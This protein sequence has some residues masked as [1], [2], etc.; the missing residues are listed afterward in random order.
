MRPIDLTNQRFGKLTALRLSEQKGNGRLWVCKCDCGTEVEVEAFGLNNGKRVSCGCTRNLN[1]VG[2]RFG[3][4]T[5]LTKQ[6][7]HQ[8]GRSDW[9]CQCECGGTCV[10]NISKLMCGIR[11]SCGCERKPCPKRLSDAE[12]AINK[13]WHSYLGN[14]R[15]KAISFELDRD[16]F[17]RLLTGNCYYCGLL[18]SKRVRLTHRTCNFLWNGIDRLNNDRGYEPD[19]VVSCCSVCNFRKGTT[20]SDEFLAW[21]ASVARHRGLSRV[22]AN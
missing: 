6:T 16:T 13:I 14:A 12:A 1:L 11:K 4:S 15:H 21:I 5:V 2:K 19:N 9:L 17:A 10:V 8:M 22:S 18:P 20:S 3:K 7:S